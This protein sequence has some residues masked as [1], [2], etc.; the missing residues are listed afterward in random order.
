MSARTT[1]GQATGFDQCSAC[2]SSPQKHAGKVAC[3]S[4]HNNAQAFHL[5]QASSPGFKNCGACHTKRHAG[6]KISQ[7]KCA[8][9]HKG[10]SGRAAAALLD[11]TKKYVCSGCHSKALHASRVSRAVKNCRTCHSTKY[12]ASQPRP[13]E[14]L[15]TGVTACAKRHANGYQCTLCHRAPS[16]TEAQPVNPERR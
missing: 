4:C 6:K 7:S 12:H 11:V 14:R 15:C 8:Q 13:R 3:A 2:H 10:S 16:I 5:Y 1:A 9:C